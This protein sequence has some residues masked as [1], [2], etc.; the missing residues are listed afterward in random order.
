M[1][2]PKLKQWATERQSE[3]IDALI[4]HGSHSKAAA[5]LGCHKAVI[6]RAIK[7]VEVKA[8]QAGGVGAG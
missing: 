7:A 3:I 1:A 6:G 8:A 5:A 2:D 4:K